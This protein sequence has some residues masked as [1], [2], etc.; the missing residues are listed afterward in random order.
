MCSFVCWSVS[1]FVVDFAAFV[2]Q[3]ECEETSERKKKNT[4]T[5]ELL[6]PPLCHPPTTPPHTPLASRAHVQVC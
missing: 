1:V 6:Y 5:E 4:Q 3:L 2:Q